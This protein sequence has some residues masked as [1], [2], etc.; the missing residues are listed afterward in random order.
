MCDAL[1]V[2]KGVFYWYFESKEALFAELLQDSLLRLRR[3]QQMAIEN[4]VDPV[5]RIAQGIRASIGF[6]RANP[7]VLSLIRIAGRYEEFQGVVERGQQIVVGDTAT[8]IKEGMA[9]GSIR[10]ADPELMAHGILGAI[11]HF[12][13]TYFDKDPDAATERPAL[14]DE[15]V[16]FCLR[17]LLRDGR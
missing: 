4:V 7:E 9:V 1:G 13:E 2:G 3:A 5:P 8:H 16:N 15:A 11:F 6:F 14:E 10:H 12:V 17:G